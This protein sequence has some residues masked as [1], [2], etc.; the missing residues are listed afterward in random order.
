MT[1]SMT[2]VETNVRAFVDSVKRA[3]GNAKIL[4]SSERKV[5]AAGGSRPGQVISSIGHA[6]Y[7]LFISVTPISKVILSSKQGPGIRIADL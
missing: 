2:D 3:T 1:F 6:I 4:D 5:K 7:L